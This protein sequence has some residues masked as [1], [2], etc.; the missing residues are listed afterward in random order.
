LVS[1]A[2]ERNDG[3]MTSTRTISSYGQARA[4]HR[5]E[6]PDRYNIAADACSFS[7]VI[8]QAWPLNG[9]PEL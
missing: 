6:V 4:R 9:G 8:A 1:D 2:R 5:S 3:P 7:C